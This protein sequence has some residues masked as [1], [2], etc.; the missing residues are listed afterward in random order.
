[1]HIIGIFEHQFDQRLDACQAEIIHRRGPWRN[2]DAVELATLEWAD[3]LVGTCSNTP[4]DPP[5][6][7]PEAAYDQQLDEMR[8]AA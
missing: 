2:L 3:C 4:G 5:P 6:A 7:E 1:M 8:M